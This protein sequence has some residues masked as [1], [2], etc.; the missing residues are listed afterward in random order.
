ML[1]ISC[2]TVFGAVD[3]D[4][5]NYTVMKNSEAFEIRHYN[6]MLVASTT[7]N[8]EYDKYSGKA[9]R[10]LADYIFGNN[11]AKDK[12]GSQEIA[13]TAPVLQHQDGDGWTM[14]FIMPDKWTYETVPAPVNDQIKL[15]HIEKKKFAA[16]TYNGTMS[17]ERMMAHYDKL[18]NWMDQEGLKKVSDP[19]HAAYNPPWTIPSQ[20]RNEVLIE[21]E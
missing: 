6:R 18:L 19:I 10:R 7:V 8:S 13:M 11:E 21:I 14:S 9:F 12:N 17:E 3:V 20:R 15:H 1:F 2:R 16:I 4:Q 5:P